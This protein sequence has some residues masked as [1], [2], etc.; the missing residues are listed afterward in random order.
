MEEFWIRIWGTFH[1][2]NTISAYHIY[3]PELGVGFSYEIEIDD[4]L[5]PEQ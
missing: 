2:T 1:L 3:E 4:D 5:N